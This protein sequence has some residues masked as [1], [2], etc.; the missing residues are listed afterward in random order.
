MKCSALLQ[1]CLSALYYCIRVSGDVQ[2]ATPCDFQS[3]LQPD[4]LIMNT[5]GWAVIDASKGS[6]VFSNRSSCVSSTASVICG[7]VFGS[8]RPAVASMCDDGALYISSANSTFS[9]RSQLSYNVP[10][11]GN[12]RTA[13]LASGRVVPA[14]DSTE[15]FSLTWSTY[16]RP[17]SASQLIVAIRDPLRRRLNVTAY[18]I[19]LNFGLQ[20]LSSFEVDDF[21]AQ[22][23]HIALAVGYVQGLPLQAEIVIAPLTQA[24]NAQ[25]Q[26]WSWSSATGSFVRLPAYDSSVPFAGPTRIAVAGSSYAW[27]VLLVTPAAALATNGTSNSTVLLFSKDMGNSSSPW[28]VVDP[29]PASS[30]PGMSGQ[31]TRWLPVGAGVLYPPPIGT[32]TETY[33]SAAPSFFLVPMDGNVSSSTGNKLPPMWFRPPRGNWSLTQPGTGN[34]TKLLDTSADPDMALAW[35]EPPAYRTPYEMVLGNWSRAELLFDFDQ[36]PRNDTRLQASIAFSRWYRAGTLGV[37]YS[38]G[39]KVL[40]VPEPQGANNASFGAD[41]WRARV[42]ATAELFIGTHYQHHSMMAWYPPNRVLSVSSSGNAFSFNYVREARHTPGVDCSTFTGAVFNLALGLQIST[43]IT[44]QANQ[45]GVNT[46]SGRVF[47]A[48]VLPIAGLSYDAIVRPGFLR[49]ADLLYIASGGVIT[50]VIMWVGNSYRN[51]SAVGNGTT[52]IPLVID[53]TATANS[54]SRGLRIP[55]GV[56]LRPFTRGS[57]YA[58]SAQWAVRWMPDDFNS[59]AAAATAEATVTPSASTSATRT[60]SGSLPASPASTVSPTVTASLSASVV[61]TS[62]I[63]ASAAATLTQTATAPVLVTSSAS[64]SV[65]PAASQSGTGASSTAPSATPTV[66]ASESSPVSASAS[67]SGMPTGTSSASV[68]GT[69]TRSTASS[70]SGTIAAS[71]TGTSSKTAAA[72]RSRSATPSKAYLRSRSGSPTRSRS[73]SGT[74][75]RTASSSRRSQSVTPSRTKKAK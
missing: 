4:L 27:G 45:T 11:V 64:V 54:D 51:S 19:A 61:A 34:W 9:K 31:P 12:G 14:N 18:S 75:T 69:G 28:E 47:N 2:L 72:S 13:A 32:D 33:G 22:S 53:S 37:D 43:G 24:G 8:G 46:T 39:P 50:H 48:T 26:V 1:L 10:G 17:T 15:P 59:A 62:S 21:G 20:A 36:P 73:S 66:T 6:I 65:T 40:K 71:P 41:F 57:W 42:L 60:A 16:K 68:S 56:Q 5:S 30:L 58:G 44:S 3:L 7:D 25:A 29:P 49:P 23:D 70:K 55:S 35:A 52:G 38:W 63:T 74:R 67:A